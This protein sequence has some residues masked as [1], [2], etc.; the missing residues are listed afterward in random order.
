MPCESAD[1]LPLQAYWPVAHIERVEHNWR[2]DTI[3]RWRDFFVISFIDLVTRTR[4]CACLIV[5]ERVNAAYEHTGSIRSVACRR[6][7]LRPHGRR[8]Q[9]RQGCIRVFTASCNYV[10]GGCALSA[11]PTLWTTK[12]KD[13]L[14]YGLQRW[15][16]SAWGLVNWSISR[17]RNARIYLFI[18]IPWPDGLVMRPFA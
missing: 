12:P 15:W 13:V 11:G 5:C 10:V 17:R 6:C 3:Y 2:P 1:K 8:L 9:C 4:E 14:V 18:D 7:V 16:R